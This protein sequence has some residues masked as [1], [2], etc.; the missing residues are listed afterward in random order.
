MRYFFLLFY[1]FST[2]VFSQADESIDYGWQKVGQDSSPW[3]VYVDNTQATLNKVSLDG[4]EVALLDNSDGDL[5]SLVSFSQTINLRPDGKSIFL[6][7]KIKVEN[8]AE[9]AGFFLN[10][11]GSSERIKSENMP[12]LP[13][14]GS[15]EWQ[16]VSIHLP[17]SNHVRSVQFGGF[18]SGPGKVW[19]DDLQLSV[20]GH[21]IITLNDRQAAP[22]PAEQVAPFDFGQPI[23]LVQANPQQLDSLALLAKVWGFVK[24]HHPQA[25]AGQFNMDKELVVLIP[26]M[27]EA[28]SQQQA[29]SVLSQWL[30]SLG[31]VEPCLAQCVSFAQEQLKQ[32]YLAWV[33]NEQ[34]TGA[35]LSQQLQHIYVNRSFDQHFHLA[36]FAER[37]LSMNEKSY[38]NAQVS[39]ARL[40]LLTLFRFWN[41]VQYYSPYNDLLS[42]PWQQS[43]HDLLPE[44]LAA[45]DIDSFYLTTKRMLASNEDSHSILHN[46]SGYSNNALF[47]EYA[48][49]V[50]LQFVEGKWAVQRVLQ[51]TSGFKQ[52][53]VIESINDTTLEDKANYLLPYMSA[54]NSTIKYREMAYLMPRI[55][56]VKAKVK[57]A[58]GRTLSVATL[59]LASFLKLSHAAQSKSIY[60]HPAKMR[61][62]EDVAYINLAK[63][64][65]GTIDPIL[66]EYRNHKG[67]VLDLRNYPEFM[68]NGLLSRF[69]KS[70]VRYA[71]YHQPVWNTP[72]KF[73]PITE[74]LGSYSG[75]YNP[76]RFKGR[77]IVLV[78]EHTQSRAEYTAMALRRLPNALILGSQTAGT[79]GDVTPLVL[80][81]PGWST[82][83]TGLEVTGPAGAQVQKLGIIADIP[84]EQT[85]S[86]LKQGKDT[87]L[88]QAIKWIQSPEFEQKTPSKIQI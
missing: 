86:D 1:L 47:G 75:L 19:F 46:N 42:K 88:E 53:D 85:V 57:L 38:P 62:N 22:L 34:V 30:E 82:W 44:F 18:L 70:R 9:R 29:Q 50:Q 35:A 23:D 21:A 25:A 54:S 81:Y 8:V 2:M 59:H 68:P 80:P 66:A 74:L 73:V 48:L 58:D 77:L 27:L 32:P 51:A 36:Q 84:V 60:E 52:G 12:L 33:L 37:I 6:T 87:Q 78:N 49:P 17:L 4:N 26:K 40:R 61:V 43:L 20:D 56:S 14:F 7:G 79:D 31:R 45:D 10:L 69:S 71:L 83:I 39:D 13:I 3:K 65:D 11:E 64:N 67:L 28:S 72:G 5:G 63:V 55:D 16:E 76:K 15:Q 41:A 24:Y